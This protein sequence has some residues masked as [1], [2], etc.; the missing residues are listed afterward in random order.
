MRPAPPALNTVPIAA[1]DDLCDRDWKQRT[2]F[3]FAKVPFRVP[4]SQL[5]LKCRLLKCAVSIA[6][7]E[8]KIQT[9]ITTNYHTRHCPHLHQ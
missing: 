7:K 2:N 3:P 1:V 4:D 9:Q 6:G 5:L 8:T